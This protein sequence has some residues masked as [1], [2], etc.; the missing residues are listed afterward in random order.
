MKNLETILKQYEF[1]DQIDIEYAIEN[2]KDIDDLEEELTTL[3]DEYEVIYYHNAIKILSEYDQSLLESIELAIE[4]GFTIENIN[5]ELLATL[6]IQD[7]MRNELC[8][9]LNEIKIN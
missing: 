4:L 1:L 3:I 8:D 7:K 6:L 5:S 9:F 2:C